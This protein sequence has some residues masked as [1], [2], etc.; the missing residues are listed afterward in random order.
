M[1]TVN[2]TTTLPIDNF[3]SSLEEPNMFSDKSGKILSALAW[4][5]RCKIPLD[6]ALR[7]LI[8]KR[9][10]IS[11]LLRPLFLN[12]KKIWDYYIEL[13]ANDIANGMPL[14]VA[15]S[16]LSKYLPPYIPTAIGEAEK[17]GALDKVLPIMAR[18]MRYISGIYKQRLSAFSYPILQ[19]LYCFGFASFLTTLILPRLARIFEEYYGDQALP[20]ITYAVLNMGP[21]L[22]IVF[23]TGFSIFIYYIIFSF[24][25]KHEP[26]ARIF[27]DFFLIRLPLIGKDLQKIALIEL[28]GSMACYTES[29]LDIITAAELSRETV[30]AYWLRKKLGLFIEKTRNGMRW[31]DAWDELKMGFPFYDW[32]ARNAA[33]REKVSEGFMQM[34]KWLKSDVSTF[35]TLF[36]KI[37][38]VAGILFNATIVGFIVLGVGYGLFNFIYIVAVEAVQ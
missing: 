7:T 35:S 38:E 29:G 20:G 37:A 25:Y 11:S 14:S 17:R 28:S 31:I 2:N 32:I 22:P 8:V 36:I 34:M 4:G 6:D 5:V 10:K 33:S 26:T 1:I 18:Q 12:K 15:I 3:S 16:H 27:A 30:R 21:I 9:G 23:V 13:A 19:F 24:F